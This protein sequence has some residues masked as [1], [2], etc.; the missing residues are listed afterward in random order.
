MSTAIPI[1]PWGTITGYPSPEEAIQAAKL[2]PRQQEARDASAALQGCHFVAARCDLQWWV[3][4]FSGPTWLHVFVGARGVD[5]KV[6]RE[7]VALLPVSEPV[8]FEWR[9]GQLSE[10]DS[11]TLAARRWGAEFWQLGV[12]DGGLLLYLRKQLTLSFHAV[13]RRDTGEILLFV[14]DGDW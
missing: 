4:E 13:E 2:H 5:W 8:V 6:S 14:C 3:I 11:R 12:N 10:M 1:R 7:P 9:S